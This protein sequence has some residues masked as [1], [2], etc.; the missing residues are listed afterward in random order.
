M[1]SSTKYPE[2]TFIYGLKC[3][4]TE[5][6]RYIGKSNRP[7]DRYNSHL[8]SD[9]KYHKTLWIKKLKSEGIKPEL[10]IIDEVDYCNWEEAEKKYI[11]LF[12]SFGA[13]LTNTTKGGDITPDSSGSKNANWGK[14]GK[15][16]HRSKS[17]YIFTKDGK[18]IDECGSLRECSRK[19]N[20]EFTAVLCCCKGRSK[21]TKGYTVR[22]KSDF[23]ERPFNIK[24]LVNTKRHPY[25]ICG[26]NQFD[27]NEILIKKYKSVSDA[28]RQTRIRHNI[29]RDILKG[30]RKQLYDEFRYN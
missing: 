16:N 22:Y 24:I 12:K 13:D 6:I 27:A 19:Y 8:K 3:P 29:I 28:Y 10:V 14:F 7:K 26:V 9:D 5:Q 15:L 21:S 25:K 1:I 4:V 20:L 11:L 18:Y 30:K 23:N 17:V 2:K